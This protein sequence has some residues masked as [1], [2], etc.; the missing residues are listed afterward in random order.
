LRDGRE[1]HNKGGVGAAYHSKESEKIKGERC[2]QPG[3]G[4]ARAWLP[5]VRKRT[6]EGGKRGG[7]GREM[8]GKRYNRLE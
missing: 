4:R 1:R 3:L 7:R 2:G 6:R 5:A 8:E